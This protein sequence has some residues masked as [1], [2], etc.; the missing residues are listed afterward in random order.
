MSDCDC[1]VPNLAM[2]PVTALCPFQRAQGP[3]SGT[4]ASSRR[5]SYP[6]SPP[7]PCCG[8]GGTARTWTALA[9]RLVTFST[10]NVGDR[11]S[12]V[13]SSSTYRERYNNEEE[14]E[15]K[16]S[17]FSCFLRSRVATVSRGS[18]SR[19]DEGSMLHCMPSWNIIVALHFV[20]Q[21]NIFV[22]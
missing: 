13:F 22:E 11:S 5:T 3:C 21:W 12:S 6:T 14:E 18:G 9:I 10:R 4:T 2:T 17:L 1:A 7:S 19:E 8:G 15:E 16:A 20:A